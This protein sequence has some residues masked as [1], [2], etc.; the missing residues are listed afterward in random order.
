MLLGISPGRHWTWIAL[1]DLLKDASHLDP[2]GFPDQM[3]GN[4]HGD[5]LIHRHLIKIGVEGYPLERSI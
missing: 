4:L 1:S 5:H 2:F 3:D